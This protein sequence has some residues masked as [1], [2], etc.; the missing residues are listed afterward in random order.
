MPHE[1][2][3]IEVERSDDALTD[4]DRTIGDKRGRP[5]P[6]MET[7][8]GTDEDQRKIAKRAL[9]CGSLKTSS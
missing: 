3:N 5:G 2:S 9:S 6:L 1:E 4:D 7:K 8:L